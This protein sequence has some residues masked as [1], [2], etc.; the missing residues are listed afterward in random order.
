M[1]EIFK[2]F[3]E[4]IEFYKYVKSLMGKKIKAN[5]FY[6]LENKKLVEVK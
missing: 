1:K 5:T 3:R 6:K 2:R 4:L